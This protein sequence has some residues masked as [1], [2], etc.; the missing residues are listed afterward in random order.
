[1]TTL[2][3]LPVRKQRLSS[4][5]GLALDGS[6][7]EGVVLR[8]T[9]GSLEAQQS[10]SVTLSLDPLTNDPELVAIT[11]TPRACASAVVW[12]ACP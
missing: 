1:M 7:L 8:R 5:L 9:N 11:L 2:L 3:K 4:L 12:W 10:F 6:R